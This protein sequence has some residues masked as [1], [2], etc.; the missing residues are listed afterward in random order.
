MSITRDEAKED[1]YITGKLQ[2]D[3]DFF[4]EYYEDKVSSTLR[5]VVDL[6]VLLRKYGH[7]D[8]FQELMFD[9]FP[10]KIV[11]ESVN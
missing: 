7:E 1:E 4:I 6:V 10:Q 11:N 5:E 9:I 8:K 3:F 2:E